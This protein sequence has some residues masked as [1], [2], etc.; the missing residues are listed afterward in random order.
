M[1]IITRNINLLLKLIF[2]VPLPLLRALII[3]T[4]I[5]SKAIAAVIASGLAGLQ[6]LEM[7]PLDDIRLQRPVGVCLTGGG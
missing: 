3:I 1:K 6:P 4:Q 2:L 5:G 7:T